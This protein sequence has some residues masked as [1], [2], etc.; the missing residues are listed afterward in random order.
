V[1]ASQAFTNRWFWALLPGER[2]HP[3]HRPH[4][5]QRTVSRFG[6]DGIR[7]VVGLGGVPDAAATGIAI[8]SQ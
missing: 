3:G 8:C 2:L 5:R 6:I 1:I 7:R 4:R